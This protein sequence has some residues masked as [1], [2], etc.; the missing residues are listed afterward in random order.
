MFASSFCKHLLH[1]ATTT[2]PY[3]HSTSAVRRLLLH[4]GMRLHFLLT[5]VPLFNFL[6][7]SYLSLSG[8]K[9]KVYQEGRQA[10]VEIMYYGH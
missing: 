8:A 4:S 5:S 3:H 9:A 6:L 1:S 10:C 7:S 2:I